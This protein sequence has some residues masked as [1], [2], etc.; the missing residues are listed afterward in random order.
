VIGTL[1]LLAEA[2]R[3]NPGLTTGTRQFTSNQ[4]SC[5]PGAYRG[6]A[7]QRCQKTGSSL[8]PALTVAA[9]SAYQSCDRACAWAGLSGV[10]NF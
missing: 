9:R 6:F 5:L 3:R 1:G 8:V 10:S 7:C 2:A 4:L